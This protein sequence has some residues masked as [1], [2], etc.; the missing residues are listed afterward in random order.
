MLNPTFQN[1]LHMRYVSI[2][3]RP[4][5]LFAFALLTVLVLLIMPVPAFLLDIGYACSIAFSVL[6]LLTAL[7]IERPLDF[8]SFPTVLL[9]STMVRLALDVASTR[10]VLS[11][12]HEGTQAAGR[13]IEAFGHFITQG[14]FV[15]GII[16]FVIVLIVNFIVITKGSSRIAEVSARFSLDAMPGKQMAID[17]DLSAGLIDEI[18]A[19]K[20]RKM[21]EE[22]SSFFGAMDGA[23]KFV[24]GDAI[25]SL[26]ITVI[27]IVG[28]MII[29]TAQMGLSF[30][31]ASHSYTILTIGDGLVSQI[32]ALIVS[33]AAGMLVS[34]AGVEGTA[35]KAMLT[36]L[37][38]YPVA[39]GMSSFIMALLAIMPGFPMVPFLALSAVTGTGAFRISQTQTQQAT[40]QEARQQQ[41]IDTPVEESKII[42]YGIDHIRIEIGFGLLNLVNEE[43]HG[44]RLTEQI[45][46]LRR[47][48]IQEIGFVL[49]TVRIQDNLQLPAQSYSIRIKE[50]EAGRG[51]L[52]PEH[53]LIMNPEDDDAQMDIEGEQTIEPTFGLQAKWIH[54]DHRLKA[55]QKGYTIVE[56]ATVLTTH[57]TE[58]V[59]DHLSELLTYDE[60]QKMLDSL[61]ENYK[62]LLNDIVPAQISIGGIQRILQNLVNERVSIRDLPTILEAISEAST[63]TRH[64]ARISE[65]VRQRL[66][67]QI[68]MSHLDDQNVLRVIALSSQWEQHML[69]ALQGEDEVKQF[70]LAPSLLQQF[71]EQFQQICEKISPSGEALTLVTNATLRPYVRSIIERI[72]PATN[73]LSH[74]EIHPS[75]QIQTA[76]Y[77]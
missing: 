61:N 48:L 53:L 71:I 31:E 76:D 3:Y 67:R 63:F 14:N 10:L 33:T 77:L 15:I 68:T 38:A 23:A 30:A 19:G 37:T 35:D 52:R 62:R 7:S 39:L 24:R 60:T 70:A 75:V 40:T 55:E 22:E 8:N 66:S 2:L 11:H 36:Q 57:L 50:L 28:G 26:L 6:I 59:K 27:N 43:T 69:N 1:L 47:Q 4:D 64:I 20:R 21:T 32:P 12:G 9:V 17:A 46:T 74:N 45:K 54:P 16:V 42:P 13:I 65:H 51:E 5:V 29:G 44:M 72:R 58:I 73:I 56:P 34:K 25:A 18:T 41:H 49:P